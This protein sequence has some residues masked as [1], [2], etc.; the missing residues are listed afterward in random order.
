MRVLVTGA[1]GCVGPHVVR[2]LERAGADVSGC[3]GPGE[4]GGLDIRDS[5]AVRALVASTEPDAVVHLAGWASVG[6]SFRDPV[7]C[8]A[9]NAMGSLHVLEAVRKCAPEA[10][11]L[12]VSSGEVY[13]AQSSGERLEEARAVAPFSPYAVSKAAAE[14]LA[15]EY[16]RSYALNVV[17]ARAFNHIGPGQAPRFAIATFADQVRK[18]ASGQH[19]AR[20]RVGNLEPIRD[21]TSVLDVAEAYVVLLRAGEAGESYNVCSGRAWSIRQAVEAL[22]EKANVEATL[23]VDPER[24]RPADIAWLVGDPSKLAALGWRARRHPLQGLLENL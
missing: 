8:F 4:P 3:G 1:N 10:R 2:A 16:H 11:V 7:R 6:E 23:E 15:R 20:L 19:P 22:L 5:E 13:G 14:Q 24:V 21:F 12:L 18:I 17:I 9:V